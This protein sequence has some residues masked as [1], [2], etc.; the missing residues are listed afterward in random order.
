MEVHSSAADLSVNGKHDF[1]N[2]YEYHV[3]VLLSEI[4]SK[5]IH[6]PKSNTTEFGAVQDDGLGRVSVLLKVQNKGEDVKVGY[7]L[8]AAGNQIKDDIKNERKNLKS[9]LNQEYGWFK[10][11]TSVNKKQNTKPPRFKITFDENDTTK[12]DD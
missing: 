7:D 1:N 3:K 11:D 4:L 5:K 9:I 6:K 8:R 12:I 10:N 2:N